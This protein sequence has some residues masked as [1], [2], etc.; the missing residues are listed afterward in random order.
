MRALITLDRMVGAIIV[1]S[2]NVGSLLIFALTFLVVADVSGRY[3][4]NAPIKGTAEMVMMSVVAVLYLQLSYTLRSG[5][6]TRSG[7]FHAALSALHPRIGNA[8][9]FLFH[10]AGACLMAAIVSRAWFKWLEAWHEGY[11][12]G[13]IDVFTFPQWPI[14]FIIFFGCSLTGL[15]F[16]VLAIGNLLRLCGAPERSEWR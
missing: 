2:N 4:F 12:A 14:L 16:A 5:R 6:M 15:Q 1:L 3:L 10:A 13:I 8:V 11:F 7:A 9:G